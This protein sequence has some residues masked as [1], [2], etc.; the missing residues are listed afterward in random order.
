L[1]RSKRKN[2]DGLNADSKGR[3]LEINVQVDDAVGEAVGAVAELFDRY[4]RGGAVI[5]TVTPESDRSSTGETVVRIKAYL[6]DN[7]QG[8]GRRKAI[9]DG[10]RRLR[11]RHSISET[12]IRALKEQDWAETWKKDYHVQ[13]IG[14]RLVVVPS[15][16]RHTVLSGEVVVL[17][18]PGM[19]FGSGR[20]PTTRLCLAALE[21]YLQLG[22]RVLDV[23][24]GSGIQA[25]AA[26]KLGSGPVAALDTEAEAIAVAR[27][28]AAL[29]GVSDQIEFYTG[30]LEDIS[31]QIQSAHVIVVNILAYTI[32]HMIPYLKAK[33]LPGGHLV[34]GG[35]LEELS[36]EVKTALV[37]GGFEL[38]ELF[39]QEDWVSIVVHARTV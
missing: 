25:I 37:K 35:I 29:N 26:V 7:G 32:I 2:S 12:E 4:G 22:Q 36:Q 19:A 31:S 21:R 20:H 6:P 1:R 11:K 8:R 39:R 15:W 34:T 16:E 27:Q 5:E 33:L 9:E 17:M 3:W 10:L 23:G 18:D 24:T 13:K 14:H 28:N 38:V 30:K